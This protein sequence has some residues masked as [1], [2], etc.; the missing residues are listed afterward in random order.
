MRL[1]SVEM[2]NYLIQVMDKAPNGCGMSHQELR[3]LL[4]RLASLPEAESEEKREEPSLLEP[5]E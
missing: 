5:L 2:I 3:S 1:I 4:E